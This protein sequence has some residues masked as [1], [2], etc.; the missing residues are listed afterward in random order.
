MNFKFLSKERIN[1]F[2]ILFLIILPFLWS[3]YS[4]E[5]VYGDFTPFT[6][7]QLNYAFNIWNN[8]NFGTN[9]NYLI[10]VPLIL[11]F[12]FLG[13][14]FSVNIV[15]HL[16]LGFVLIVGYISMYLLMMTIERNKKLATIFSL[17]YTLGVPTISSVIFPTNLTI[18][19]LP[20]AYMISLKLLDS[21]LKE[22]ILFSLIFSLL[23]WYIF[24]N[25]S[26]AFIIYM[27]L[28]FRILYQIINSTDRR[29]ILKTFSIFLCINILL[30]SPIMAYN[31]INYINIKNS[32]VIIKETSLI[33]KAIFNSHNA[34]YLNV[35]RFFGQWFTDDPGYPIGKFFYDNHSNIIYLIFPII[36]WLLLI[37]LAIIILIKKSDK[38][39]SLKVEI[40][41]LL[42]LLPFTIFLS[43]ANKN[44]YPLND[45]WTFLFNK[46]PLWQTLTTPYDRGLY[47]E[48]M[49]LIL[50]AFICSSWLYQRPIKN[51]I[52]IIGG[53]IL[54]L[55]IFFIPSIIGEG[56]VGTV[57]INEP[58]YLE[59]F[60]NYVNNE[61][62]SGDHRYL[63][64]PFYTSYAVGMNWTRIGEVVNP[65]AWEVASDY[66][67]GADIGLKKSYSSMYFYSNLHSGSQFTESSFKK[68]LTLFGIDRIIFMGDIMN[69]YIIYPEKDIYI[70]NMLDNYSDRQVFGQITL[71][72]STDKSPIF[73]ILNN[74][75]IFS[76][77]W[78]NNDSN[79][80]INETDGWIGKNIT[81]FVSIDDK[82]LY[83]IGI[84]VD[85]NNSQDVNYKISFFDKNFV[86]LEDMVLNKDYFNYLNPLGTLKFENNV[87]II[88]IPP[89][90]SEY[91]YITTWNKDENKFEREINVNIEEVNTSTVSYKKESPTKWQLE[92]N[93]SKPFLLSFATTYD[94]HWNAKIN[95]INGEPVDLPK[96]SPIPL[97]SSV[98]NGFWI[99]ES[100]NVDITIEY[101][102]QKWFD[103]GLLISLMTI[104]ACCIGYIYLKRKNL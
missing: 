104:L 82:K 1:I 26:Y 102:L 29:K 12:S 85:A 76:K 60:V 10:D 35:L 25:P 21:R 97:Y 14:F 61:K 91:I 34:D 83:A 7:E 57:Q 18:A 3:N 70:K 84:D 77:Y 17:I 28:F 49:I 4:Y 33:D 51:K 73:N 53:I 13:I 93:S 99:D 11:L 67:L 2:I 55:G 22:T 50:L 66:V 63:V 56:I 32:S 90:E 39:K 62:D 88:A 38:Y 95:K 19:L 79:E 59:Q 89:A 96:I 72:N 65:V 46:F 68:Y 74:N 86:N 16:W 58:T 75:L 27:V 20:F 44:I 9:V 48:W 24:V 80:T 94:K 54:L 103:I 64:L 43:S 87:N 15:T 36:L 40:K 81:P 23:T 100:G 52:L 69:R 37:V 30:L 45:L 101:E 31:I 8:I 78:T 98:I 5:I 92:I 41:F 6:R 42:F 47:I 71:Y